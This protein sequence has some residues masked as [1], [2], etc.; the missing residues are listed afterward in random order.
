MSADGTT[1]K[2][3]DVVVAIFVREDG[4]L[5]FTS[6]PEG[7]PFAGYWEFPGGKVEPG[8]SLEHALRRE[9]LEE[10]GVTIT[11]SR[12]WKLTEY[13]YPHAFVRLHWCKVEQWQGAFK[14]LE[15]QK[16]S[17]EKFPLS[18]QPLLPASLPILQEIE[19]DGFKEFLSKI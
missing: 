2:R 3:V 4:A 12:L 9:L 18:I 11:A 13:K 19:E 1:P 15:A 10:L 8:E 16:I 14:S 17:W 5:L 6:R 7:K